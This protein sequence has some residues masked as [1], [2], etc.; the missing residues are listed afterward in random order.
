MV[1]CCVTKPYQLFSYIFSLAEKILKKLFNYNEII[2]NYRCPA[3]TFVE[4]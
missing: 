3:F 2:E 1:T 4:R